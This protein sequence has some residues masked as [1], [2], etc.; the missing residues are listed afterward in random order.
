MTAKEID[1]F[2]LDL[3]SRIYQ[4][5]IGSD[6]VWDENTALSMAQNSFWLADMLLDQYDGEPAIRLDTD[7]DNPYNQV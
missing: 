5:F 4:D 7:G 6:F 2:R 3:A 1:R